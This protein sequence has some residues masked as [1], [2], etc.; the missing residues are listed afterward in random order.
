MSEP[1]PNPVAEPA[2]PPPPTVDAEP[3]RSGALLWLAALVVVIV[4]GVVAAPYWAPPVLRVLPWAPPAA[5]A[6]PAPPDPAL[7]SR[8]AAL[9]AARGDDAKTVAAA[10]ALAQRI[11]ALEAKPTPAAP[12]PA[13]VQQQLAA[14]VKAVAEL[15][16]AVARLD[17]AALAQPATDPGVAALALTLLQIRSALDVA[18]PF[19]AEYQALVALARDHPDIAAAAA[20]LE[21]PAQTGLASR[22]A[23]AD[24]LRQLAPLIAAAQPPPKHG[25]RDEIIGEL[26]SLVTIRRIG[27]AAQSPE[28]AAI[29]AAQR[30][31]S[32][33]AI[34]PV[35][36]S[37]SEAL[38]GPGPAGGRAVAAHGA[39]AAAGGGDGSSGSRR[40]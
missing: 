5:P 25:W 33:A 3:R 19:G 34:S 31:P 1:A 26:R 39:R 8:I 4:A 16:V 18:R 27:G 36:S 12:D 17:K 28:E 22:A 35:R 30:A 6:R 2:P 10:Q 21:Q 37:R 15:N 29:G 32:P 23:L 20:P 7:A 11:A 13:P 14:L 40:W 38:V 9:E 24:R